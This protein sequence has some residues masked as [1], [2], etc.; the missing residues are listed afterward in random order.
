MH[1]AG[2]LD[3]LRPKVDRG[4]HEWI[5]FL[6]RKGFQL[7]KS[8]FRGEE[9]YVPREAKWRPR[10]AVDLDYVWHD[11]EVNEWVFAYGELLGDL[12]EDWLGPAEARVEI[13]SAYD[14]ELRRHAP[15]KADRHCTEHTWAHDLRLGEAVLPAFPDASV[16]LIEGSGFEARE[17]LVEYDRTGRPAKNLEKF[18]RYDTLLT[19]GWRA[20]E[21]FRQH[22]DLKVPV[23]PVLVVFVCQRGTVEG[24]MRAADHEVTG[25][26]GAY[27]SPGRTGHPGRNGI[28]FCEAPDMTL[29]DDAHVLRLPALPPEERRGAEFEPREAWLPTLG[30]R[31]AIDKAA[32]V[33]L[34][35]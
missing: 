26:I 21:R 24:F 31:L 1:D 10:D 34:P 35:F 11:L 6:A 20:V 17:I 25:Q 12:L 32:A 15:P 9:T 2:W 14:S 8:Y 33:E 30:H 28:L 22:A 27:L 18:R 23:A 3:R 5:Y 19:V 13:R 29:G 16:L 4:S 7:G